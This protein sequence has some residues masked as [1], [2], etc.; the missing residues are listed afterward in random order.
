MSTAVPRTT[1]LQSGSVH[2]V[3]RGAVRRDALQVD[4]ALRLL[5]ALRPHLPVSRVSHE[6]LKRAARILG[7][8]SCVLAAADRRICRR[9]ITSTWRARRPSTRRRVSSFS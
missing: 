3:R 5:G 4:A 9:P 8:L 2:C 7:K 1:G 6:Q